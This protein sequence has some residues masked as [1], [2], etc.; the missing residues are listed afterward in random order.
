LPKGFDVRCSSAGDHA[1]VAIAL[2]GLA[3]LRFSVHNPVRVAAHDAE[4]RKKLAG[5]GQCVIRIS[6]ARVHRQDGPNRTASSFVVR[7]IA[8][9]IEAVPGVVECGYTTQQARWYQ[10]GDDQ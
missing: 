10:E 7:Q 8:T 3:A 9:L 6:D 5:L 2:A 4:G 1:R